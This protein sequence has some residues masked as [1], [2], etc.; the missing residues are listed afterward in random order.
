MFNSSV[1]TP[2]QS[3]Q[4]K[5]HIN[6]PHDVRP[7]L[8]EVIKTLASHPSLAPFG[9]HMGAAFMALSNEEYTKCYP[10][11]MIPVDWAPLGTLNAA[12]TA[13]TIAIAQHNSQVT[14]AGL[15][16][17]LTTPCQEQ[18]QE[19]CQKLAHLRD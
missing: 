1:A 13:N 2:F 4:L 18:E 15:T 6:G 12:A 16:M 19:R 7:A 10:G 9:L 3:I 14:I 5:H 11:H 8:R 17:K